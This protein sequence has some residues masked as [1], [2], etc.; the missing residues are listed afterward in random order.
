[1]LFQK[2]GLYISHKRFANSGCQWYIIVKMHSEQLAFNVPAV[3][4]ESE[5]ILRHMSLP[6]LNR[7]DIMQKR[8]RRRRNKVTTT[9]VRY[10]CV[11]NGP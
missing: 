10:L 4:I 1:M 2:Q 7:G 9:V 5:R 3:N 11:T 6:T 8:R